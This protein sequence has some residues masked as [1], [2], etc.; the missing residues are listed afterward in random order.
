VRVK[1]VLWFSFLC[2][3]TI[4]IVH[5]ADVNSYG[6][7]EMLIRSSRCTI[8][9]TVANDEKYLKSGNLEENENI[10]TLLNNG[11]VI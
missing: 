3:E 4:F 5:N 2:F 10:F 6:R 8:S 7:T 11:E 1:S 9:Q